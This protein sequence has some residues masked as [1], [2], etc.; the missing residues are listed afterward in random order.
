MEENIVNDKKCVKLDLYIDEEE[1]LHQ[2]HDESADEVLCLRILSSQ[3][4]YR[5]GGLKVHI[6]SPVFNVGKIFNVEFDEDSE[7]ALI[8]SQKDALGNDTIF[9]G[10]TTPTTSKAATIVVSPDRD[11]PELTTCPRVSADLTLI[12]ANDAIPDVVNDK[13]DANNSVMSGDEVTAATAAAGGRRMSSQMKKYVSRRF[14]SSWN[15]AVRVKRFF[16]DT[17]PFWN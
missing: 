10:K 6:E 11:D 16:S 9:A 4:K 12:E 7:V 3:A 2:S 1:T 13:D 15:N 14:Q 5:F 17:M 8:K